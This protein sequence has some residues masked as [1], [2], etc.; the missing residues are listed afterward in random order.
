MKQPTNTLQQ[1]SIKRAL[2]EIEDSIV[3]IRG[4]S[5]KNSWRNRRAAWGSRLSSWLE[6]LQLRADESRFA[7]VRAVSTLLS[8]ALDMLQGPRDALSPPEHALSAHASQSEK[9]S[10]FVYYPAMHNTIL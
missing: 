1:E 8:G 4:L 10:R 3:H 2:K 9:P 5:N 7:R 6:S